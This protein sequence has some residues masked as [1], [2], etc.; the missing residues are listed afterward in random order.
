MIILTRSSLFVDK[1]VYIVLRDRINT[2]NTNNKNMN[3]TNNK[4]N[5]SDF[6]QIPLKNLEMVKKKLDASFSR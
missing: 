2:S 3:H 1:K 4:K 6:A 5:L